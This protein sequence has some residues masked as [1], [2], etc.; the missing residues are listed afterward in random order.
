[1]NTHPNVV[2][3]SHPARA[4]KQLWPF[5]CVMALV[6]VAWA[7]A[8][9]LV[10]WIMP[11]PAARGQ[12]GDM[13]GAVNALFSGV[14]MAGVVYAIFLQKEELQ[15]QRQELRAQRQEMS[16]T[17]STQLRQ[18]HMGIQSMAIEE[19]ELAKVWAHPADSRI[20][21]AQHAY[22]NLVLSHW[23]MQYLEDLLNEAQ[24]RELLKAQLGQS[25][26]FREFW[27]LA[28][29][30]RSA[31]ATHRGGGALHFHQMAQAAYDAGS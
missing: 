15:L 4:R 18:L 30:H 7:M 13:F 2:E 27:K 12:F 14:A 28:H 22:V 5:R 21:F 29:P 3:S 6:L 1:M 25:E 16:R 11:D 26:H 10:W 24:I 20:S 8:G 31:M 9:A 23:E 19:P 17:V